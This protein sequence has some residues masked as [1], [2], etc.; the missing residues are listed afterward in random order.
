MRLSDRARVFWDAY[1]ARV[2]GGVPEARVTEGHAGNR[3]ITDGL[4]ALYLSGRKTA[5]SSLVEDFRAAGDP[6]PQVGDYW[7]VLDSGDRPA[8]IVKTVRTVTTPFGEVGREIA[9][10]EGEGDLSPEYWRAE[11]ARLYAPHLERW[12]IDRLENATVITEFFDLVWP[13]PQ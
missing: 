11:H 10:A 7:I 9:E 8:C 6:L 2:P 3:E 1:A 12:G 13:A 5:G 4:I